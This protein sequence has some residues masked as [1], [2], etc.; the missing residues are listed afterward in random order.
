MVFFAFSI[1]PACA[2][3][4]DNQQWKPARARE[5]P[6]GT[7]HLGRDRLGVRGEVET[8]RLAEAELDKIAR[9]V[10][11]TEH[12]RQPSAPQLADVHSLKLSK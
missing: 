12:R 6:G 9:G 8:A 11:D 5:A 1:A 7:D 4:E 10:G 2:P 3:S